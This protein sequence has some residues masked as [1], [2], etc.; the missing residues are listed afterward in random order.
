MFFFPPSPPGYSRRTKLAGNGGRA[1]LL[2]PRT[3][4]PPSRARSRSLFPSFFLVM[5]G[6]MGSSFG[7]ESTTP[8]F[9]SFFM[10]SSSFSS[11]FPTL[12]A[13]FSFQFSFFASRS[14]CDDLARLFL[15]GVAELFSPPLF[16][17]RF[18][19]ASFPPVLQRKNFLFFFCVFALHW[20]QRCVFSP[21]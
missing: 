1:F 19:S 6:E 15:G 8:L 13:R 18:S 3:S 11:W 16:L 20:S 14:G 17:S 21:L 9:F 12:A 7:S 2:R 10:I 5:S 4:T